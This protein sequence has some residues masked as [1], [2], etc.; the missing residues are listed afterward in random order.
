MERF[1][2]TIS[3]VEFPENSEMKT[4]REIPNPRSNKDT[5]KAHEETKKISQ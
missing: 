5:N 1:W 3:K 4:I 2:F